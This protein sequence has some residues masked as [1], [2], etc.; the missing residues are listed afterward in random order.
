V[1]GQTTDLLESRTYNSQHPPLTITDVSGQTTTL[2]YNGAG[3]PA[4]VATPARAGISENRTT[5]YSYSYN[6][7]GHLQSVTRPATGAVTTYGYDAYGRVRTVTDSE[8][9]VLT[10]DY[11]ALDRPTKVTY[12]MAYA[13]VVRIGK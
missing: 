8:G 9:Y 11:D 5:I 1:S 2:T 4:T 3:R 10:R 7:N 6:T 12:R 13:A